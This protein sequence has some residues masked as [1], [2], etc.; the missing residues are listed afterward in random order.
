[1]SSRGGSNGL[2]R[3]MHSTLCLQHIW[4]LG[5]TR[6]SSRRGRYC[7]HLEVKCADERLMGAITFGVSAIVPAS[8][9]SIALADADRGWSTPR[10]ETLTLEGSEAAPIFAS[11]RTLIGYRK[12]GERSRVARCVWICARGTGTC[13]GTSKRSIHYNGT[14][15]RRFC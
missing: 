8:P 4:R 14:G 12:S 5:P 7:Y 11:S 13:V 6:L 2:L 3:W 1:M 9:P 10:P 15:P